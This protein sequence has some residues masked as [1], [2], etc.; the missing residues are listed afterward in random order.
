VL[1]V[2]PDCI[3]SDSDLSDDQ[4]VFMTGRALLG[5]GHRRLLVNVTATIMK[6]V[7]E[8]VCSKGARGDQWWQ[9]LG[10]NH[11]RTVGSFLGQY[12]GWRG[13]FF[14]VIPLR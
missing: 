2:P 5:G 4:V 12:V 7:P 1:H 3:G 6:L 13:A 10:C 9:R 14:L 11:R 8:A